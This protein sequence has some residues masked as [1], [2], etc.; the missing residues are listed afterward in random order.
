MAQTLFLMSDEP[1]LKKMK[2]GRL[3]TLLAD[4]KTDEQI[5]EELFLATLSR[6]PDD[7]EKRSALEHVNGKPDRQGAFVDML[8]AL[9]NTREF[10]LKH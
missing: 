1:L 2:T 7:R 8:W 10:I 5:V 9:I 4:R 3:Q 6:Y